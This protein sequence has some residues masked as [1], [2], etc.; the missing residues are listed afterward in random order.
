MQ[1]SKT[2]IWLSSA[3][4]VLAFIAPAVG[5]FSQQGDSAYTFTTLHG[6]EIEIYGRGL[7]R[8]D[9][10]FKAPILRGADAIL[11]FLGIPALIAAIWLYL[12]GS[13]RGHFLLT[14]VLACFLYNSLSVAFGAAFNRLFLLYVAYVSTSLFAF[15]LALSSFDLENLPRHVSPHLPYKTLA[16]FIFLS[17]LSAGVW[18]T[19]LIPATLTGSVPP[20]LAHYTTDVTAVIDIGVIMPSA[21][22]AGVLLQQRKP[23]GYP[24][25]ATLL[26]LLSLIGLIVASQSVMQ[27]IDGIELSTAEFAIFVIPFVVLSLIADGLVFVFLRHI[28][29]PVP[30][31]RS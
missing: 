16:I 17:S 20:N 23:L 31:R 8:D 25:A 21:I 14:G 30:R 18:L 12:K 5:L 11:L 15:V 29:E 9:W 26:I 28:G 4:A 22:L 2:L 19:D 10:I 24:L 27:A 3:V 6:E 1:P 7:Y 13:L